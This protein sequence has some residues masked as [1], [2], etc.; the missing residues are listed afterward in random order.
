M[1][2][3]MMIMCC[4]LLFVTQACGQKKSET[5][6]PQSVKDA[7]EKKFPNVSKIEWEKENADEWEAE[8][9][10]N[11]IEYSANFDAKGKWQETEHEIKVSELPGKVKS[12]LDNDFSGYTIE[13]AEIAETPKGKFYEVTIEKGSDEMEVVINISG[14]VIKKKVEEDED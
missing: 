14:E 3:V 12:T 9:E 4:G 1:K 11:G 5:N 10:M 2:K 7:F 6:V 8:F 13:E